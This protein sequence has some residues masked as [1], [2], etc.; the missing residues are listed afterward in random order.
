M[1]AQCVRDCGLETIE[2]L[3][4]N[5]RGWNEPRRSTTPAG[6]ATIDRVIENLRRVGL[7][8]PG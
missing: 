3:D 1:A 8:Q 6:L 7:I 4:R 5:A 2:A